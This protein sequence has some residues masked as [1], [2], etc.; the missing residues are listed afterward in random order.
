ML[1]NS[2]WKPVQSTWFTFIAAIKNPIK[3]MHDFLA[4]TNSGA[5]RVLLFYE[6]AETIK[7]AHVNFKSLRD[8]CN[9]V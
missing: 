6:A 4:N 9:A 3:I 2:T 8:S 1:V 5:P 7:L